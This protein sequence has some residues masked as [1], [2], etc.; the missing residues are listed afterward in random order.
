[1]MLTVPKS[2]PMLVPSNCCKVTACLGLE[3]EAV[4]DTQLE[5]KEIVF[6]T[7]EKKGRPVREK[8][9]S[10]VKRLK[11]ENELLRKKE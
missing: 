1:M 11:K 3:V 7:I 6:N 10:M 5:S 8:E 9:L 2:M 4:E